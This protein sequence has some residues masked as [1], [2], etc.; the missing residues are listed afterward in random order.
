M[1]NCRC[2]GST[3]NETG[4]RKQKCHCNDWRNPVRVDVQC[5]RTGCGSGDR[6]TGFAER[7]DHDSGESDS[8]ARAEIRRR[9]QRGSAGLEDLVAAEDRAAQGRAER[10]VDHDGRP[11][12]RRQ[13]HVRR[14]DSHTCARPHRE[15]RFALHPVQLDR[16][17]FAYAR[18]ADHR[19]QSPLCR[20]R[21]DH[22]TVDR[23]SRLRLDHRSRQREHR[24]NPERERLRD[25]VV[26]QEPQHAGVP[27]QRRG[28]VRPVA[29]RHG[30][31]LLLR[32]H[33]RRDRSVGAVSVP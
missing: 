3:Q 8:R 4:T 17:V 11:G 15:I 31:R 21:R 29:V 12:L 10:P 5:R 7:N 27:V 33:G 25:V 26:R 6:R 22:R 30:L 23:L 32:L 19:P 18:R 1:I 16:A 9:H 20:Q 24:R 2:I 13:R 14:R 28:S